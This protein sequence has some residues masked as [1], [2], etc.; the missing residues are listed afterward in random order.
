MKKDKAE[1]LKWRRLAVA[2]NLPVAQYE[3]GVMYQYGDGAKKDVAKAMEWY[4]L[5]AEQDHVPAQCALGC[6]YRDGFGIEMD[7]V[8]SYA[9]FH[10]S[11]ETHQL[12]KK[13]RDEVAKKMSAPQIASAIARSALLRTRIDAKAGK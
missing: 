8:E 11:A 2:Q 4:R 13:W 1:A 6:M 12:S 7:R 5:A 3:F 9:W 10:L